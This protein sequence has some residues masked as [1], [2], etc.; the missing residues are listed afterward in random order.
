M[1]TLLQKAFAEAAK[2]PEPEQEAI[3]SLVLQ[4]LASDDRWSEAFA[5]SQDQLAAL[6]DKALAEFEAGKTLPLENKR[7][8]AHD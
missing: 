5:Q 4:E 2:R 1:T 7:D 6:A 3:A 8:L